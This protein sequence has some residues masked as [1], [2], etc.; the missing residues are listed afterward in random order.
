EI[1]DA[2][3]DLT[4]GRLVFGEHHLALTILAKDA[5]SLKKNLSDA[6]AELVDCNM[7]VSREDWAIE[8]AFWSMLPGNFKYRARPAPISS[9]NFAG[10]S[11]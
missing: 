9:R 10:F 3:D 2:L 6:K 7:I 8:S 1:D 4:S 5:R 11:S